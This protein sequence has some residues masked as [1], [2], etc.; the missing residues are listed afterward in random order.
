MDQAAIERFQMVGQDLPHLIDQW[1]EAQPDTPLLV[2]EPRDG[3]TR[4]WTYRDFRDETL[5]IA[6]GLMARGSSSAI[7]LIHADN[8]PEMV[9]AWYACARL[10]AVGVT[11]NT[12]S[13]AN[14][15]AYFAEHTRAVGA[16]TQPQYAAL[17]A[18][19]APNSAGW[20]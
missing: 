6:A 17:V 8:C 9:L 14:E 5:E 18:E 3:A 10:G 7:A 19:A 16:I 2:W 12:R 11:T 20:S 4:T 1:V 13:V 15:V